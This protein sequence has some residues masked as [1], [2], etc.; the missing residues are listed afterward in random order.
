MHNRIVRFFLYIA[1]VILATPVAAG[2]PC[3]EPDNAG[4]AW[5][6]S[7]QTPLATIYQPVNAAGSPPAALVRIRWDPD[8]GLLYAIIRDYEHFADFIPNVTSSRVVAKQAGRVWV[9]Q[10][11]HLPGPARDRHYIMV[12]SHNGS[13][14]AQHRYHVE[15]S[16]S[17]RYS[18]PDSATLISPR[19]FRG[20][21]TIR[22]GKPGGLT[23]N[24]W[25]ELDPGG[26]LPRWVTRAA[27]NH[28][29][30]DL[31]IALHQRVTSLS[32]TQR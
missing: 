31:M 6:L 32:G 2:S 23:A 25:I 27:L 16:L 19:Q 3:D 26:W 18:L 21:W 17:T 11:L 10:Q 8:P 15:W 1:A 29:I 24:Y 22:A 13:K 9:Y 14:P 30:N 20:C 12:S 7:A 4:S 5:K 28:Y